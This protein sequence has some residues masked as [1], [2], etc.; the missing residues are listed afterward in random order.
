MKVAIWIVFTQVIEIYWLVFPANFENFQLSGLIV[1]LGAVIGFIGLFGFVVLKRYE[2]AALIPVGDPR[3][4]QSL[5][6]HQ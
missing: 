4:D 5:H 2:S 1:T 3:L 6:H